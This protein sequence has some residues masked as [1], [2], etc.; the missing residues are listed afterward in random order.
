MSWRQSIKNSITADVQNSAAKVYRLSV[1]NLIY[2]SSQCYLQSN[3]WLKHNGKLDKK[4]VTTTTNNPAIEAKYFTAYATWTDL[5]QAISAA[6]QPS[7]Q[8]T[9]SLFEMEGVLPGVWQALS[10]LT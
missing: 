8:E 3:Q 9:A 5:S 1:K 10:L 6:N 2:G 7:F 4:Q